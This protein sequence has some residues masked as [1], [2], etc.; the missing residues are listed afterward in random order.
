MVDVDFSPRTH[1]HGQSQTWA[2]GPSAGARPSPDAPPFDPAAGNPGAGLADVNAAPFQSR[3][4]GTN[5][6]F[7]T[8]VYQDAL[9]R[10]I[11]TSGQTFFTQALAAGASRDQ[12][13]AI[14]VSSVEFR[15][16][17]I[18]PEMDEDAWRL[19]RSYAPLLSPGL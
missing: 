5:Q 19:G 9:G 13:A 1:A 8:A 7:L 16:I 2:Q 14:I 12:V 3:G 17:A 15:T 18:E 11:D 4:G 6:G 10:A